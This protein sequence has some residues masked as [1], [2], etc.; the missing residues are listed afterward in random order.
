MFDHYRVCMMNLSHARHWLFNIQN[1]HV[2]VFISFYIGRLTIFHIFSNFRQQKGRILNAIALDDNLCVCKKYFS[3]ARLLPHW[4]F[5]FCM[6]YIT[7]VWL[8]SYNTLTIFKSLLYF[9]QQ[10]ERIL[11]GIVLGDHLCVCNKD[12]SHVRLLPH[13]IFNIGVGHVSV[14]VLL[15]IQ[16]TYNFLLFF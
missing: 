11:N 4:V 1:S 8:Y 10:N 3:H 15:F 12:L 16:N 5:V 2:A 13:W 6:I 7:I 14:F 9:N